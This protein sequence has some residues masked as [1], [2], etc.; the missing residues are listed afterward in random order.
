MSSQAIKPSES[1][2]YF[3]LQWW[4]NLSADTKWDL[5]KKYAS[6][7]TIS[8]VYRSTSTIVRMYREENK[9]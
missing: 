1:E 9:K 3:A 6:E 5:A 2:R 7:W 4:K 8:W